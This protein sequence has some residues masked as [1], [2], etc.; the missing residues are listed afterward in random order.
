M[1]Q[2]RRLTAPEWEGVSPF[3]HGAIGWPSCPLSA[4]C[5]S[6]FMSSRFLH[7]LACRLPRAER[8]AVVLMAITRG[9]S[10]SALLKQ[11]LRHYLN[12]VHPG[13]NAASLNSVPS[14]GQNPSETRLQSPQPRGLAEAFAASL[15]AAPNNGKSNGSARWVETNIGM[16]GSYLNRRLRP[17]PRRLP[18]SGNC[19]T[20]TL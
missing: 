3:V 1:W 2:V 20:E 11:A 18:P 8:E 19:W 14:V 5:Y 10:V 4:P 9:V 12:G 17:R 13:V 16:G 6:K 15:T 7:P